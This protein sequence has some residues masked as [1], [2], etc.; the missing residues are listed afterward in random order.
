MVLA[1]TVLLAAAL[2]GLLRGGRLR[3][4]GQLPLRWRPLVVLALGVQL[5]GAVAGRPAY[6]VGLGVSAL[7]VALFLGANRG[8]PGI[9][10]VT[11]G[12]LANAV[13]V[14]GNGAMPVS[15]SAAARAGLPAQAVLPVNDDRHEPSGTGTRLRWLGDVVP[16][17][18]P[19]HA[20]VV[21]PGDVLVAAGLAELVV[22]GMG[23]RRRRSRRPWPA[24]GHVEPDVCNP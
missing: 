1:L 21:S 20:E 2:V 17:L 16:V 24:A 15:L 10:L 23:R 8:R 18:L 3:Q 11:A 4:L 7:L 12:L 14:G 9:G 5:A 22:V 19:G 13:V 6:R